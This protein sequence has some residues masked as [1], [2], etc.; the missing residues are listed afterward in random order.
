MTIPDGFDRY[1][2]TRYPSGVVS[3]SATYAGMT[4]CGASSDGDPYGALLT[5]LRA[6]AVWAQNEGHGRAR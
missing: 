4:V 6:A 2:V 3:V 5:R 1:D